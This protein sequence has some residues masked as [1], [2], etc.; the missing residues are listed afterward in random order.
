MR[1]FFMQ[2]VV[3]I[4]LISISNVAVAETYYS[5]EEIEQ[6]KMFNVIAPILA[7]HWTPASNYPDGTSNLRKY[8]YQNDQI[9]YPYWGTQSYIV[10]N[11]G[12]LWFLTQDYCWVTADTA[13]LEKVQG[14]IESFYSTSDIYQIVD[15]QVI[16]D[17][18]GCYIN[19][20]D[21]SPRFLFY[22]LGQYISFNPSK[23]PTYSGG[24]LW[25]Y[26][27][28]GCWVIADRNALEPLY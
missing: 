1:S 10:W 17:R 28:D 15:F 19:P 22:A 27:T 18:L 2:F 4:G 8:Y 12:K 13:S 26:T 23:A 24:K 6:T 9:I 21:D 20:I 3:A 16:Q 11:Q 7:C 14:D 25:F 5:V